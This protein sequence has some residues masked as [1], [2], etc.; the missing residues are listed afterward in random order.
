M[1]YYGNQGGFPAFG[2]SGGYGQQQSP[3]GGPQGYGG[4]F[5]QG[6]FAPQGFGGYGMQRPQMPQGYGQQGYG[7]GYGMQPPRMMQ[8]RPMQMPAYQTGGGDPRTSMSSPM[9][10]G[11][12]NFGQQPPT[13]DP[14]MGTG[15]SMNNKGPTPYDPAQQAQDNMLAQRNVAQNTMQSQMQ[16]IGGFQMPGGMFAPAQSQTTTGGGSP[17]SDPPNL[18]GSTGFRPNQGMVGMNQISAGQAPPAYGGGGTNWQNRPVGPMRTDGLPVTMGST[19]PPAWMA[20]NPMMAQML[21]AG[22][23]PNWIGINNGRGPWSWER[24]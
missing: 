4:G 10:S 20:Q 17:M 12:D 5:G 11:G 9:S 6:M 16:N 8:Q 18:G 1:P 7:G 19:T 21:G 2:M 13:L 14:N 15:D 23:N 24:G 3:Y 22:T